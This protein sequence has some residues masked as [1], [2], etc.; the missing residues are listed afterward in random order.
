MTSFFPGLWPFVLLGEVV[1]EREDDPPGVRGYHVGGFS[2]I[3]RLLD[4]LRSFILYFLWTERCQKH[5]DNQYSSRKILQQAW[6]ATVE[7]GMATSKAINSLWSSRD[8]SIQ[9]GIDQAFKAEWCHLGIFGV[10]CVTIVW[11]FLPPLY[12]LD[13]FNV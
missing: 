4:I 7:V 10:E 2:Y 8:P 5:F 3:R 11:C 13:F 12:F 9:D 6:V 1:F